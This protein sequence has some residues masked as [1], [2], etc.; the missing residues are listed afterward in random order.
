MNLDL[1]DLHDRAGSHSWGYVEPAQAA[2]DLLEEAVE[3]MLV[4]MKRR[5]ELGLEAASEAI[6]ADI[7]VGLSHADVEKSES[8][9][10]WAPD[11]PLEH[12]G[13]AVNE[14]IRIC[15]AHKCPAVCDRLS[16]TLVNL[17][18][19]WS[20]MIFRVVESAAQGK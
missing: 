19:K 16:K 9:L 18:P 6:C 10:Q 8:V 7:V 17:V 11:F 13:W 20:E 15:P 12:A 14:L 1:D 2:Q 4:D 3:D 5:M